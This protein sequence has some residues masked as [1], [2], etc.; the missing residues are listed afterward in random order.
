MAKKGSVGRLFVSYWSLTSACTSLMYFENGVDTKKQVPRY[1]FVRPLGV[2]IGRKW[3]GSILF[4]V[5]TNFGE[6]Y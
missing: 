2:I 5:T 6:I 1:F 3:V 4:S